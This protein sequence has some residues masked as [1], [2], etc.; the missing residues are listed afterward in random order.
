VADF[1][2]NVIINPVP[3]VAGAR[4]VD[5]A[6]TRTTARAGLLRSGLLRA[7]APLATGAFIVKGVK[8]LADFGQ[9][10]SS[11]AAITEAVG[12]EFDALREKAILLGRDTR[13]SATEAAQGM[14][15]L[16]RAGFDAKEV[17][18]AI[19][20]TLDLA[21]AGNL[22]LAR[23]ADISSNVLKGFRLPVS[24]MGRVLD[25]MA[26]AA[27]SSNTSVSQLG[28][29]M[30]F[31][32]PVAAGLGL[33]VE[34]T[35]AAIGS[36]SDAGLQASLGGTG[37]RKV[38][39]ELEAPS[40]KTKRIFRDLG[41]NFEDVGVSASG[42]ITSLALLKQSG[43]DVGDALEVFGQRGG[44]AFEVMVNAVPDIEELKIKLDGAAGAAGRMA[45]IMDDNLFGALRRVRSAF[46]TLI[47]RVGD[48]G[49]SGVLRDAFES[50]AE[51]LRFLSDNISK[52]VNAVQ[53]ISFVVAVRQVLNL[54]AAI[55]ALTL[56]AIANPLG[57]FITIISVGIGTLI[58]FR[59]EITTTKDS[60]TTLGDV[61]TAASDIISQAFDSWVPLIQEVGAAINDAFGGAFDGLTLDLQTVIL[62]IAAFVDTSIG[63]FRF[64]GDSLVTVFTSLPGVV[65]EVVTDIGLSLLRFIEDNVSGR[66]LAQFVALGKTIRSFGLGILNFF[67]AMD[68]S[69][70]QL[71]QGQGDLALETAGQAV[72]LLGNQALGLGKT[73][74]STFQ[75]ELRRQANNPNYLAD[76]VNPFE[77]AGAEAAAKLGAGFETALD[78]TG[79]TDAAV[80]ALAAADAAAAQRIALAAQA[81]A[82]AA[83]NEKTKEGIELQGQLT[84]KTAEATVSIGSMSESLS[85]G[86]R[87]GLKNGLAG[88]TDVSGAAEGLVVNGFS[89]AE[90]AIVSF[91]TTGEADIGA[92]IDG[93]LADLARLLARQALLGLLNAVT[94]GAAGGGGVA[95]IGSLLGGER[96]EGGPVQSGVPFLV[97]ERGPE[98]F[99]PPGAGSIA[100]AAATAGA[101]RGAAA[102]APAP[103]VNVTVVNSSTPEDTIAAMGSAQGTQ[104]IMNAISQNPTLIKNALQ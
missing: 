81:E 101:G 102:P 66:T 34:E 12:E 103:P 8:T 49:A 97:G 104:L 47:I 20:P 100:T 88:L 37:L 40:D 64:L 53:G 1:R 16:A 48:D 92:L 26:V 59:D 41:I 30:K 65:G 58:A 17:L 80:A 61:A 2:I 90:D 56:A 70:T 89:A 84:G 39:G 33:S 18:E 95:G 98:L 43:V 35:T 19:G 10:M 44:P 21:V 86:L 22:D 3:A 28:D 77:G 13:F 45:E 75:G 57:A 50:L 68:I 85:G 46:E 15:F 42:L 91:A 96:A 60:F 7:L 99:I 62:G 87:E 27:N 51:G 83:A 72:E 63:L 76:I 23:A 69:L 24:E 36:L 78:F 52:F 93:I 55:K 5:A 14:T 71:A 79:A 94:G 29:A 32:A 82:Q 11:V 73:F 6:L 74:S 54:T 25:V 38:L 67:R 4:K 9:A 31:V